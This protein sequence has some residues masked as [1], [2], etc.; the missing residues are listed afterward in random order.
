M[1]QICLNVK[2]ACKS[3]Y[4]FLKVKFFKVKNTYIIVNS[5]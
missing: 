3:T 5:I 1:L 4:S 2:N